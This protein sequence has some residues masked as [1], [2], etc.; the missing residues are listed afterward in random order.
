MQNSNL[1]A[2]LTELALIQTQLAQ[3]QNAVDQAIALLTR[4]QPVP[5]LVADRFGL[6]YIDEEPRIVKVGNARVHLAPQEFD[7]LVIFAK[8]PNQ[9]LTRATIG[10]RLGQST[11]SANPYYVDTV[12]KKLR[13]KLGPAAEYI[14]TQR[15]RGFIFRPPPPA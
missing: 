13:A 8:Q 7:V 2:A 11:K 14:A 4:E 12:V 10:K 5:Q 1:L 6:L 15:G 3:M 9:P